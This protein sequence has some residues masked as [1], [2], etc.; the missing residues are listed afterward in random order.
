VARAE[1]KIDVGGLEKLTARLKDPALAA[2]LQGVA[3][4]KDVAAI[5]AQAIADNFAQEGP[6]WAPLKGSTIRNSIALNQATKAL[7]KDAYMQAAYKMGAVKVS[8]SGKRS[9]AWDELRGQK[10]E[11][12]GHV[13]RAIEAVERASRKSA[14]ESD[15]LGNRQILR[16]TSLLFQTVTRPNFEGSAKRTKYGG[17]VTGSNIY[18]VQGSTLVWGTNLIYAAT[19]NN[20]TQAPRVP[21]RE[22]LVLREEWRN[23]LLSFVFKLM[24]DI[25]KN[26]IEGT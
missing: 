19:H 3:G 2:K 23:R 8:K 12:Y 22:F 24:S 26:H 21:K 15:A 20:G 10:T 16:R 17:T 9:V 13:D 14:G 7:L 5:V 6:G 18:K 1:L 11:F 4:M 25:V